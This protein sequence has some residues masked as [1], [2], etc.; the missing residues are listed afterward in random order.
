M[1]TKILQ[2][3]QFGTLR[4][5]DLE[6]FERDLGAALPAQ[7]RAFLLEHNGGTPQPTG[8]L[9][10]DDILQGED[11]P[12]SAREIVCFYALRFVKSDDITEEEMVAWPLQSALHDFMAERPDSKLIPIGQDWSGNYIC[13]GC[14]G[15]SRGQIFFTD[16]EYEQSCLLAESFDAFLQSLEACE[17]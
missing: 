16:H 11:S 15:A 5:T 8:F 1:N 17:T 2:S 14:A 9:A 6:K 10:P 3:N 12:M 13:I 7:Y 4:L